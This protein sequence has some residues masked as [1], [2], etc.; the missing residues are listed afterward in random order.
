MASEIALGCVAL[1]G[2]SQQA[3]VVRGTRVASVAVPADGD[4]ITQSLSVDESVAH[5]FN[6]PEY[7]IASQSDAVRAAGKADAG[8][9]PAVYGV[10]GKYHTLAIIPTG[11]VYASSGSD[12]RVMH[13][14]Q[15][16]RFS[17]VV[18]A[19]EPRSAGSHDQVVTNDRFALD[20]HCVVAGSIADVVLDNVDALAGGTVGNDAW[21]MRVVN[22]IGN[23]PVVKRALLEFN[24]V[25][26][27]AT[28]IV[29][30]ITGD[31]RMAH[32]NL[33]VIGAQIHRFARA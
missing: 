12:D 33:A 15:H 28:A 16:S 31:D 30:V 9:A 32:G 10:V 23:D 17:L 4:K 29:N 22:V 13:N 18:C 21:I 2:C 25:A 5:T 3:T 24:P 6:T 1:V 7:D 26:L 8:S 19:G 14:L 20:L 27:F 11:G